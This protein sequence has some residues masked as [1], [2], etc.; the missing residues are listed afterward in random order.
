[1]VENMPE[2]KHVFL[3]EPF[4]Y[5]WIDKKYL[6]RRKRITQIYLDENLKGWTQ[7][8]LA[9]GIELYMPFSFWISAPLL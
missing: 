5:D 8:F 2:M 7:I 4:T 1:M 9:F 3:A 6:E